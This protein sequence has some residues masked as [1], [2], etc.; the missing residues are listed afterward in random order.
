MAE[1]HVSL[2]S[3]ALLAPWFG[4]VYDIIL[5][6]RRFLFVFVEKFGL[7]NKLDEKP[8]EDKYV[9]DDLD[10]LTAREG[11]I[12]IPYSSVQRIR[13][14]GVHKNEGGLHYLYL[15][16]NNPDGKKKKLKVLLQSPTRVGRD[17]FLAAVRDS[18]KLAVEQNSIQLE[19]ANSI[20]QRLERALPTSILE[21]A[22]WR[23]EYARFP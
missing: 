7:S 2:I 11:S 16:Y 3:K 14:K 1:K 21:D 20:R 23:I 10:S 13:M 8:N 22:E 12:T 17:S 5:T 15:E 18:G 9:N 4:E 6:D 19:Y